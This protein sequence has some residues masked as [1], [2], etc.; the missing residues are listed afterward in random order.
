MPA[1]PKFASK[2]VKAVRWRLERIRSSARREAINKTADDLD[3][4]HWVRASGVDYRFS[5]INRKI[6]MNK[7]T[8]EEYQ[9]YLQNGEWSKEQTDFL[10][11]LC[12]QFDLRFTIIHDRFSF[13]PDYADNIIPSEE[14]ISNPHSAIVP[15]SQKTVEDLKHRF[16]SI[17]RILLRVRNSGDANLANHPMFK[18]MYNP[19]HEQER[20]EQLRRL[21]SRTQEDVYAMA[22]LTLENRE[23]TQQIK[24]LK[25]K[26]VRRQV[27]RSSDTNKKRKRSSASS[28]S[29][30]A[31]EIK[32]PIAKMAPIPDHCVITRSTP[33]LAPGVHLRSS[34]GADPPAS[35]TG[36]QAARV[37]T[38]LDALRGKRS[39]VY[40]AHTKAV[41]DKFDDL[42]SDILTYL[43]LKDHVNKKTGNKRMKSESGSSKKRL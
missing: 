40:T 30:A 37:E 34:H 24:S 42:R 3:L 25:A 10:F 14:G 18:Y 9:Q 32:A 19:E 2:K 4:F 5:K 8:H 38:E 7:Y 12:E 17:Q 36:R 39:R 1:K 29:Y 43:Q 26:G 31:P 16:Y 35:C 22:K 21:H 20:K 23:L 28:S 13:A 11:E 27:T 33:V 15:C 6:R 41:C